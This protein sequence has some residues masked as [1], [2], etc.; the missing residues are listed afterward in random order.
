MASA[1]HEYWVD[2]TCSGCSKAVNTVVGKVPGVTNI[3]ID[4]PSK[5]VTVTGTASDETIIEAIKKTGK[6]NAKWS[7]KPQS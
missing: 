7:E 3:N 5:K 2:M 4:L 1:T 6:K